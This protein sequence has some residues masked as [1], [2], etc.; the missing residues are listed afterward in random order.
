MHVA[1][2]KEGNPLVNTGLS[3]LMEN[4]GVHTSAEIIECSSL[5]TKMSPM[6]SSWGTLRQPF[7]SQETVKI[8]SQSALGEG[9]PLAAKLVGRKLRG[10]KWARGSE[11]DQQ[12]SSTL[13][14]ARPGELRTNW[15][16]CPISMSTQ[17]KIAELGFSFQHPSALPQ[18]PISSDESVLRLALQWNVLH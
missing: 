1:E 6:T 11:A 14:W 16:N 12:S 13:F 4:E 8:S 18:E 3:K 2:S 15:E 9:F 5:G 17:I 10:R 7:L